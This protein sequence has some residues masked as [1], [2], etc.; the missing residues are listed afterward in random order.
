MGQTSPYPGP[1]HSLARR[2]KFSTKS[3]TWIIGAVVSTSADPVAAQQAG[4]FYGNPA[5]EH[6]IKDYGVNLREV[7]DHIIT[8]LKIAKYSENKIDLV[9]VIAGGFAAMPPAKNTSQKK[10]LLG[11]IQTVDEM[12]EEWYEI[13]LIMGKNNQVLLQI[14]DVP[15]TFPHHQG[16]PASS[17]T[18]PVPAS[19]SSTSSQ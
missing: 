13:P 17:S 19:M 7:L 10:L 18:L 6:L 11:H 4:F 1:S 5:F 2:R 8:A 9:P 16:P 3:L 14:L 12:D 15:S